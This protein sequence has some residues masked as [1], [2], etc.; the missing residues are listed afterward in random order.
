MDLTV[1]LPAITVFAF[2]LTSALPC[3]FFRFNLMMGVCGK[4]RMEG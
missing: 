2:I 4:Q 3:T 1:N